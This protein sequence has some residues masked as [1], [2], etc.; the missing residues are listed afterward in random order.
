MKII[1][2]KKSK[3]NH[4]FREDT[5]GNSNKYCR[6]LNSL[7]TGDCSNTDFSKVMNL[8]K[9]LD[10]LPEYLVVLSDME[11]DVGSNQSKNQLEKLWKD[12][13]KSSKTPI[14]DFKT[15]LQEYTQKLDDYAIIPFVYDLRGAC[16][17]GRF[18]PVVL[19]PLMVQDLYSKIF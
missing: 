9:K 3:V 2:L 7:Y 14:K 16:I 12:K 11:F 19:A 5:F 8:L 1:L 6:E 4:Y 10:D 15:T 13:V 18:S 17:E